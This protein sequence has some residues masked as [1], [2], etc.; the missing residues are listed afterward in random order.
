MAT[1]DIEKTFIDLSDAEV[2]KLIAARHKKAQER[3]Q[4]LAAV[5]EMKSTLAHVCT[6]MAGIDALPE[7]ID[8]EAVTDKNGNR[9]F[10]RALKVAKPK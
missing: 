2:D 5:G 10:Y 1:R 3:E 8:A 6:R 7:W 4:A 9:N